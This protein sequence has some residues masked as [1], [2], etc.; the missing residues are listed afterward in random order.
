MRLACREHTVKFACHEH[1]LR[2]ACRNIPK[3][4]DLFVAG[5]FLI[6]PG[7]HAISLFRL[8]FVLSL[9]S[10]RHF[11]IFSSSF[12]YFFLILSL[13]FSFFF[14]FLSEHFSSLQEEVEVKTKKL[15]KLWTKYQGAVREAQDLQEEFQVRNS[16]VL[17]AGLMNF[18]SPKIHQSPS[19][20]SA[21]AH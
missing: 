11:F 19:I 17:S 20:Q 9:S 16:R 6:L 2:F 5:T 15:K 12:L 13:S 8:F 10:L 18:V 21:G 1:T 14:F 3:G 4:G 7:I